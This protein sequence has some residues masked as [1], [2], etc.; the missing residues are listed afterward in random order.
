L[1][2]LTEA[3]KREVWVSVRFLRAYDANDILAKRKAKEK[4]KVRP[5][6]SVRTRGKQRPM[7]PAQQRQQMQQLDDT[8]TENLEKV[9]V[10]V[11]G[12]SDP[13]K[14]RQF[15]SQMHAQD[16]AT[17]REWLRENTPGID[18]SVIV[19]C[20]ECSTDHTVELPITESFFRPSKRTGV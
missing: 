6:S 15:V 8:I 5:G 20:P 14:I 12:S 19:G 17:V 10:N 3:T 13:F 18:N 2:Y 11:M 16:T 7:N 9:I 1:P 4:I